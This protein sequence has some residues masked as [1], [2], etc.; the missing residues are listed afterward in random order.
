MPLECCFVKV[1]GHERSSRLSTAER[2]SGSP[3][4]L[5]NGPFKS[6]A[7]T[8][9]Q[10]IA[11]NENQKFLRSV[12]LSTCP[13]IGQGKFGQVFKLQK[14]FMDKEKVAIKL[15]YVSV[16]FRYVLPS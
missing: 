8:E 11:L 13:L 16:R 4:K 7:L 9:E 10:K 15:F 2:L 12:D 3:S 6:T 5:N 14:N 1:F